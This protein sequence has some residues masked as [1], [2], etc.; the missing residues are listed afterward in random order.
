MDTYKPP[1]PHGDAFMEAEGVRPLW[2]YDGIIAADPTLRR[3]RARFDLDDQFGGGGMRNPHLAD[4]DKD[5]DLEVAEPAQP[6]LLR[7]LGSA[8]MAGLGAYGEAEI[9]AR[10]SGFPPRSD[11]MP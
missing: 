3:A 11:L 5:K 8:L 6:G 1:L 4:T 10:T 7:R 9:Q 2:E